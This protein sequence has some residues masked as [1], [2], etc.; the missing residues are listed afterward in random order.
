MS[1]HKRDI[2]IEGEYGEF[3]K[4]E[5]ELDEVRESLEQNNKVM[6]LVELSDMIGAVQGYLKKYYNDTITLNDLLLM[7]EA[8]Q[9]AFKSGKRKN[10]KDN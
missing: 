7:N 1:Y 9:R 5:E 3:S 4:I 10:K 6:A 2:V 8:T